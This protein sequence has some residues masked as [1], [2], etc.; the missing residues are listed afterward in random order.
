M[1]LVKCPEC[2]KEIF[3]KAVACIHCGYPFNR[4]EKSVV[5]K[6]V[7]CGHHDLGEVNS[8]GAVHL[9]CKKCGY[10]HQLNETQE[11]IEFIEKASAERQQ[12]YDKSHGNP[13][14]VK[15]PY[16][17]STSCNK[18]GNI[19]RSLSVALFG[20]GSSKLGKQWHCNNCGSEW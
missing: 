20:I 12:N 5:K 3:D 19:K 16:C 11:H 10:V 1:A 14:L 15:C 7:N 17:G 6:C 9:I 18:I 4:E 2:G 13:K 8:H